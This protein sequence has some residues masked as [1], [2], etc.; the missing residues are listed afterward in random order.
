MVPTELCGTWQGRGSKTH[1]HERRPPVRVDHL[2]T[3]QIRAYDIADHLPRTLDWDRALLTLEL[4]EL[5]VELRLS[6]RRAKS[7]SSI[8]GP[9]LQMSRLPGTRQGLAK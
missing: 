9:A 2:T 7:S 6:C 5:S 4:Q 8:H 3:A 1:R